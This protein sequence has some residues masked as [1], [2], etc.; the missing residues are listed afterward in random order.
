[1]KPPVYLIDYGL[2]QSVMF[3]NDAIYSGTDDLE[4]EDEIVM[5]N[6][7]HGLTNISYNYNVNKVHYYGNDWFISQVSNKAPDQLDCSW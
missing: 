4:S 3:N 2:N 7:R 5:R 1:M 6:K